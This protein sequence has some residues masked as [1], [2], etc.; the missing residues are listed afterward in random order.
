MAKVIDKTWQQQ[1][2]D[3]TRQLL[4]RACKSFKI[5]LAK[6][7]ILF[8]LRGRGAGQVVMSH[9]Q[10]D[11]QIRYN[12]ALLNENKQTF[13]DR[14]VPH[15]VAHV[16]AFK[17]YGRG[18]KPHGQEWKNVMNFFGADSSTTHHFNTE[19]TQVRRLKRFTYQCGCNEYELTTIRHN[20]VLRGQANYR[21]S[22][23]Q[24]PLIWVKPS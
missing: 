10:K 18:I 21:C 20:R 17:F 19:N 11:I 14:T 3:L 7:E 13:I 22:Q 2:E 1:A 24:Q 9:D 12:L 23:C 6:P 8:N 5:R 15:E 16:I 4:K